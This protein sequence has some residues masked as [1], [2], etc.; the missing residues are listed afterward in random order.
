MRIAIAGISHES[1]T[2]SLHRTGLAD[3]TVLRG[4]RLWEALKLRDTVGEAVDGVDWVPILRATAVPGGSIDPQAFDDFSDEIVAGL[5]AE[6][7]ARGPLDGVYLFLHGAMSIEGRAGAEE[8]LV[9]RVRET[10]GPQPILSASMDPHGNMSLELAGLLDLASVHRHAPHIDIPETH[11]RAVRNLIA[12]IKEGKRPV[13]AHVRIPVLLPGERTATVVEPGRTVFGALLPAIETYGVIDAGIWIGF[14]WAD[15]ARNSAAVFVSGWDE[16]SVA[17]C[18]GI[19][20]RGYWDARQDFAI[21]GDHIGSWDEALDFALSRPRAP[22]FVSDSGDNVSAG[23]SG[24]IT[25]ALQSTFLRGDVIQSGLRFLFTGFV[26]P[27]AVAAAVAAGEGASIA[28]AIGAWCDTR[29]AAPVEQEW[30]VDRILD[31]LFGEGVAGALLTSGPVSVVVQTHRAY[32]IKPG[33]EAFKSVRL[34]GLAWVEPSDYDVVVVKNGYLFPGQASLAGSHFMA[35]T[36][37]G[38]DLDFDRLDFTALSRPIFPFDPDAKADLA[39]T[40]LVQQE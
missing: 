26:D 33:D 36:P 37:G 34:K 25:F 14:A 3:F 31:G 19:L 35:L 23:S 27:G 10:V 38:T 9:R 16:Q 30:T 18:A 1:S 32:F 29:Y 5:K 20:A 40:I 12:V 13:R 8:A 7:D 22:L 24:D 39:A 6:I 15:E 21:I 17:E 28:R 11:A 4:Q 2:F